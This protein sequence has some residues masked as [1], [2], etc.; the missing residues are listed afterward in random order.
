MA[1]LKEMSKQGWHINGKGL[2]WYRFEKGEPADYDCASNMEENVT[3]DML[4]IF[5]ESGWTPIITIAGL[6]IYRAEA[7]AFVK[8]KINHTF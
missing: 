2:F 5:K 1:L 6:Q 3:K 7:V 4:S 8:R